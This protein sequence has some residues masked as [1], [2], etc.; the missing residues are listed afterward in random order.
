MRWCG[1]IFAVGMAAAAPAPLAVVNAV[2]QETEGGAALPADFAHVPGETLF[3]T[4]QVQGYQPAGERVR[5]R[6]RI[7]AADPKGV[8]IMEPVEA[9]VEAELSPEDKEWKP[10][11][12]REI[13]VP[14][15]APS[16]T[17]HIRVNVTDEV[18]KTSATKDVPFEVRGR[19]VPPSDTVVV[20]N[21]RFF[22][23]ED[24]REPLTKAAYRPGDSVFAR[25]DITG[26]KY[27]EGNR[28]D[29]AYDVAVLNA[30]GKVLWEQKDAAVEQSQ[31]FYP[32][33]YVPGMMS[34]NLQKNIRPGEYA[35]R[36]T[37]RDAVGNQS[38]EATEKFTVEP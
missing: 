37:V 4:F 29:V 19:D 14:P 15:L 1:L 36:V 32:K 11:V 34:L 3:F 2:I 24:D 22:R 20:R 7:E 35:L 13:V 6:Y 25:F 23:S 17:Y 38:C 33:R 10:R 16:G 21:F 8:A 9:P 31:S 28:V 5:L 30:E 27:G 26:Y 12:R 18:A